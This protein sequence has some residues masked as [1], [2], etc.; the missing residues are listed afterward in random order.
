MLAEFPI[1]MRSLECQYNFDVCTDVVPGVSP[2]YSYNIN[3]PHLFEQV[4]F[5]VAN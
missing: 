5:K 4:A 1:V 3:P 2:Y